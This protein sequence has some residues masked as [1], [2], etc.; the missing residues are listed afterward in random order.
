MCSISFLAE[1]A[2]AI[3]PSRHF[4]DIP[5]IPKGATFADRHDLAK[6]GVH[7]P[8]QAGISGSGLEGADSIV[9]SGGY[10]D[11]SDDGDVITYT[12]HGGNSPATGKQVAD[13]ELKAGNLALARTDLINRW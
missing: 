8:P 3:M 9:L 10:E 7:R 4:G 2:S 5:G 6:A 12:G 1:E 11:D 13:Q